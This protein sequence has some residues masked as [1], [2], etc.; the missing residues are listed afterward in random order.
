MSL[1]CA[2]VMRRMSIGKAPMLQE[3]APQIKLR[4]SPGAK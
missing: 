4:R 2:S 1:S 3:Q